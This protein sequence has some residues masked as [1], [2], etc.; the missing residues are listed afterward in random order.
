MDS[1][2]FKTLP[3]LSKL[4]ALDGSNY[5]RWAQRLL[6][7]FEQ[8]EIDYVL[9]ENCPERPTASEANPNP[10]D[11][12]EEKIKK[13]EKAN[14]LVRGH[15]LSN[16]TNVL[17]DLFI[18][19]KSA[20][21]I[22]ETLEKKYGTDDAGKKKYA[23][24]KWLQFKMVD[25]KPIMNQVHEYENLVADILTEGMKMCDVLQANVLIEKLHD[26]WSNYRNHL[27]HKKKDMSLEELVSHMKIEEANRLKDKFSS[28]NELS[29]KANI[30]ESSVLKPDRFNKGK[31]IKGNFKRNQNQKQL[32]VQNKKMISFK[33]NDKYE[34]SNRNCFTCGK[35]GHKAWQ[36][37]HRKDASNNGQKQNWNKNQAHIA[38]E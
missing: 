16:M 32:G 34:K 27:R 3:D 31:E 11:N 8:L 23:T 18:S 38:E 5:K 25:D 6:I 36:C 15:L 14:K 35:P 17:F 10:D 37:Y 13:Y 22:W 33:K 29:V 2:L 20:K 9:H 28:P 30:V 21:A 24:G 4:E 7:F 12:L 19:N 1:S 26:T